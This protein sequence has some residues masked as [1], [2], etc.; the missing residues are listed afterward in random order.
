MRKAI[1]ILLLAL[2]SG[3]CASTPIDLFPQESLASVPVRYDDRDWET[4]LRDCVRDGAVDY[5]ALALNP[6]PLERY[7]A[8]VARTGPSSTPQDFTE[9]TARLAYYVNV[10]NACVLRAVLAQGIPASMHAFG[11][12][13]LPSGYRFRVDGQIVTLEELRRRAR[14][15]SDSDARVELALCDA[16]RGSP[17]LAH[18]PVRAYNVHRRLK[19]IA[20]EALSRPE[21]AR[22]DHQKHKIF[23]A[24]AI[25]EQRAALEQLYRRE[26]HSPSSTMLSVLLHLASSA[27][28]EQLA[29]GTGYPVQT[30]SFDA[31]LN[32]WKPQTEPPTQSGV[33][34]RKA[35]IARGAL[36]VCPVGTAGP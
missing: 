18:R 5:Q 34:R 32:A 19:E 29:R 33:S 24:R 27:T 10:Y 3:N 21:I 25:W 31:A 22:V 2:H 14:E 11:R 36:A 12:P 17:P 20:A 16:A 15:E 23:V 9:R 4:V 30:M 26:T 28:R 13:A 35:S 6:A 8:L 7:L 1:I